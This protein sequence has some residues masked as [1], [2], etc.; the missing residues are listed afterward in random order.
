M[1]QSIILSKLRAGYSRVQIGTEIA[2]DEGISFSSGMS[3][4]HSAALMLVEGCEGVDKTSMLAELIES[5][6]AVQHAA[7]EA[8]NHGVAL[9]AINT[10]AKLTG[11]FP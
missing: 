7:Y 8:E 9:S 10:L 3:K 1:D 11:I 2:K 4:V 6:K 5:T